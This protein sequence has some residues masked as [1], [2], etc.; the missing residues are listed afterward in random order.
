VYR[1]IN[2]VSCAAVAALLTAGCAGPDATDRAANDGS[3]ASP[4]SGPSNSAP[5]PEGLDGRLMFSRFDESTHTFLSTHLSSPDG[6]GEVELTLPGPEG[7][8]R[9]SHSGKEIAVMTIMDD[10]RVGTAIIRPDGTVTRVLKLPDP[11][12]NLV[13]TVWRPDDSRLA[14]EGWDDNDPSRRG[15]Y[16]VDAANGGRLARLTAPPKNA[17]DLPGDYTPDGRSLLFKRG[18]DEQE[19]TLMLLNLGGNAKPEPINDQVYE[20]PGRI[21]SDGSRIATSTQG[22]IVVLGLGGDEVSKIDGQERYLF[23]PAWSPDGEWLAYSGASGGPFADIFLAH[24]D[25]SERHQ[26]TETAENEI[27]IDWGPAT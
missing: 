12:L 19:G 5:T 7:G 22:R 1:L 15:I 23:G 3:D 11:S 27:N 10:D 26:I 21:S 16:E 13:C 2:L 4:S 17:G 8:G 14:C 18:G 9:W 25:G 20:D 6:S 24:P